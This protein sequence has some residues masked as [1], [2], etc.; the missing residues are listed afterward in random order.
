[1]RTES[2]SPGILKND[3]VHSKLYYFLF[4]CGYTN[5]T[6]IDEPLTMAQLYSYLKLD[7]DVISLYIHTL[8]TAEMRSSHLCL[9][10]LHLLA[11]LYECSLLANR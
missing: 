1:M 8:N 9:V 3:V 5:V 6:I 7:L 4:F 11:K 2:R 10:A